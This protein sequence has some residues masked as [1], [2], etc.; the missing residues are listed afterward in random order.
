MYTGEI[1]MLVLESKEIVWDEKKNK[2]NTKKHGISFPES[3]FVF[4][5]PYL[6][7]IYDEGHSTDKETRWKGIGAIKNNLL[8]VVFFME[9][10]KEIRLIS[11]REATIKEKKDYGENIS[12]IFGY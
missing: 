9:S 7:L 11:A 10:E 3:A 12:Q 4:L 1:Y 2:G 6:V 8:I 5:D